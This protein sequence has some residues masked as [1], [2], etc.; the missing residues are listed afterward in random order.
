[1]GTTML[2]V[3]F[4]LFLNYNLVQCVLN[5]TDKFNETEVMKGHQEL[6]KKVHTFFTELKKL[7]VAKKS[8]QRKKEKEAEI[9]EGVKET[10]HSNLRAFPNNIDFNQST[11]NYKLHKLP[12]HINKPIFPI[13]HIPIHV[14]KKLFPD[15]IPEQFTF[16]SG[17]FS[18]RESI[19][20][21][22]NLSFILP[23]M[24]RFKRPSSLHA[25][26]KTTKSIAARNIASLKAELESLYRNSTAS[27]LHTSKIRQK[28]FFKKR[29]SV[30]TS[31]INS[32]VTSTSSPPP[33]SS[34][35]TF[36]P[37]FDE[38]DVLYPISNSKSSPLKSKFASRVSRSEKM[39]TKKLLRMQQ[40][41]LSNFT[42]SDKPENEDPDIEDGNVT[43]TE[44]PNI[45]ED[46]NVT[47]HLDL[48]QWHLTPA[49]MKPKTHHG[50]HHPHHPHH[51]RQKHSLKKRMRLKY[52]RNKKKGSTKYM[53]TK[54]DKAFIKISYKVYLGSRET[55]TTDGSPGYLRLG[56]AKAVTPG[57]L[58]TGSTKSPNLRYYE[59]MKEL[60]E[61]YMMI[62]LIELCRIISTKDQKQVQDVIMHT[63]TIINEL[64]Q[65]GRLIWL[66]RPL[67]DITVKL[68]RFVSK[69]PIDLVRSYAN[70][71]TQMLRERN[72]A[73]SEEENSILDHADSF[74][75]SK[76][77]EYLFNSL[78]EFEA[79]PESKYNQY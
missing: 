12:K 19:P 59:M 68:S 65:N 62:F 76:E 42:S 64:Q 10:T 57:L 5:T 67:L 49:R 70:M 7:F 47:T 8:L 72:Q 78:K 20:S 33:L 16:R 34:T 58:P 74:Y 41:E 44:N 54:A 53:T 30:S 22:S 73:L 79:F 28:F 55:T 27:V 6:M 4:S 2:L 71:T 25:T 1:M 15:S 13:T 11:S 32:D 36:L 48:S 17:N 52:L 14:Y 63:I 51:A 29:T 66:G 61:G 18:I 60:D 46:D 45:E 69:A 3:L 39:T 56:P 38:S 23:P 9:D 40:Q 37:S 26:K 50:R 75:D 77:G 35:S 31:N 24:A 21:L 43:S